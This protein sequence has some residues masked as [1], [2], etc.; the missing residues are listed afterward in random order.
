VSSF[1]ERFGYVQPKAITFHEELPAELR[2]GILKIARSYIKANDL[3]NLLCAVFK[4]NPKLSNQTE[5]DV[6]NEIADHARAV[7]WHR[8]YDLLEAVYESLSSVQTSSGN[9][10]HLSLRR[11]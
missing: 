2:I 7:E 3:R 6:V 4:A 8:V 10:L 5:T 1:S 9:R 11:K